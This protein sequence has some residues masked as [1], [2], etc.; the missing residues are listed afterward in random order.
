MRSPKEIWIEEHDRF[1][2]EHVELY[3]VEPDETLA[4][5]VADERARDRLAMLV[6]LA[7]DEG[8]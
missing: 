6:D 3:G 8:R 5:V 7:S 1:V 2:D 4:A